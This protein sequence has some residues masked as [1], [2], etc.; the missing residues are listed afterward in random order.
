MIVTPSIL[1]VST[2]GIPEI[3]GVETAW[4]VLFFGS[5]KT[6][7]W[8]FDLFNL[9][10]LVFAHCSMLVNSS[11]DVDASFAGIT[12]YVSSAYLN[13]RFSL[14]SGCMSAALTMNAAGP[15]AEP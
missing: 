8:D 13:R 7:C 15:I 9:R 6:I 4:E 2:L 11:S 12:R 1:M 3:V 14:W 5:L 10:L